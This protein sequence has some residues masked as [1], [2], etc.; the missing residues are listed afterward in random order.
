VAISVRELGARGDGTTTDT[1]ALQAAI[2]RCTAEGGGTVLVPAGT[3]LTAPLTLGDCVTLHL[4]AGATL[5]ATTDLDDYAVEDDPWSGESRRCGLVTAVGARNVSIVGR[6]VIDGGGPAFVDLDR[7]RGPSDLDVARTRQGERY[8]DYLLKST[9]GP[10]EHGERPGNLVRFRDCENVLVRGVTI[11]NSPTWTVQFNR[12]DGVRVDGVRIHSHAS[13]NRVPNDDGI[14]LRVCRNVSISGCDIDTGDDCIAVFGSRNVTVTGCTLRSRSA[15]IRLSFSGGETRNCAIGNVVMDGCNRGI[16]VQVRGPGSVRDVEV[17]G[18]VIRT[19]LY[20]GQWWGNGEPIHVSVLPSGRGGGELGGVSGIRFANINAQA[21]NGILLYGCGESPI[22]NVAFD[23]VR[24]HVRRSGLH[25][26]CGGNFDLRGGRSPATQVFEH[27]VPGLFG[28]FVRGLDVR[29]MRLSWDE[30]LPDF[31]THG[32]WLEEFRDLHLAGFAGGP[33]PAATDGAAV[34]LSDGQGVTIRGC[35]ADAG[36]PVFLRH[37]G[38]DGP[39]LLV[40]NDFS[41]AA[42]GIVPSEHDFT[43]ADNLPPRGNSS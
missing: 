36:T 30:G 34:A 38:V 18:A 23:N 2:D 21:E 31:F 32:L 14:D 27:D 12:C 39:G 26:A 35:R 20:T 22:E 41:G 6:G 42:R 4:E 25:G 5:V 13:D 10:C 16:C 9:H 43:V 15:G 1:A 11:C 7:P 28:R 37:E 33:S 24:L 8:L 17:N 19:Q 3:Y 40:G 29:D